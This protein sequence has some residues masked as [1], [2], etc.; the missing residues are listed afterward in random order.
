MLCR[1]LY[2]GET[3]NNATKAM[4]D[5]AQKLDVIQARLDYVLDK[6]SSA[7]D[8]KKAERQ[9][10]QD[11]KSLK[12][13]EEC[14]RREAEGESPE[15]DALIEHTARVRKKLQYRCTKLANE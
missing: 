13:S 11:A 14:L 1:N 12:E 4:R 8:Y 7:E 5:V 6:E 2:E 3:M 15:T 10:A 9:L